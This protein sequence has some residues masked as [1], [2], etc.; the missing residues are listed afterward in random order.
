MSP[1]TRIHETAT[2]VSFQPLSTKCLMC[3][4]TARGASH[5]QPPA[6]TESRRYST[7]R[8]LTT[9]DGSSP[10]APR[11]SGAV[12]GPCDCHPST[13]SPVPVPARWCRCDRCAR[14]PRGRHTPRAGA[15]RRGRC[16][17]V[18]GRG[19]AGVRRTGSP[20][21]GAPLV[22]RAS[23]PLVAPP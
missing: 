23:A 16:P 7:R 22:P 6:K 17:R 1:P 21:A 2:I 15:S 20:R 9:T 3:G 11:A 18:A 12:A 19:A 14:P 5:D 10:A 4:Q 13:R 8:P